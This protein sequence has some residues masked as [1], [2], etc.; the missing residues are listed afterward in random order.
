MTLSRSLDPI[1]EKV[2]GRQRAIIITVGVVAAVFIFGIS[3]W[4]TAPEWV[5]AFSNL[6]MESVG[7]MTEKLQQ[8]GVPYKLDK[9]GTQI[10]VNAKDLARARVMLAKD[11][12][13]TAGRPG[14]ELFDQPSWGMTDFTQRINYRRALEGELERTISKMRGV[15]SAQV[16][17]ALH[18][19]SNFR[20]QDKPANASIVLKTSGPPPTPD[21]VLGIAHLVAGSVDG[22]TSDRVTIIDDSGRLLSQPGENGSIATLTNSQ[23]SM[24]RDVE[25]YLQS[26]AEAIVNEIAGR[27]NGRVQVSATLNFDKIDRQSQ[28]VDPERQATSTEQRHDIVE[29]GEEGS[30]SSNVAISYENS[31]TTE[32]FSG[33][34]GNISRLSVAVLVNDRIATTS[35]DAATASEAGEVVYV[36]RTAE[37]VAHIESLVRSAV[38]ANEARGDVV[39]VISTRFGN[40]PHIRDTELADTPTLVDYAQRFQPAIIAI[41]GFITALIALILVFRSLK[42]TG[43]PAPAQLEP[44]GVPP[45]HQLVSETAEDDAE[46]KTA[47]P[48]NDDQFNLLDRTDLQNTVLATIENKP[49]VAARAIRAWMGE[50]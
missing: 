16:H 39:T 42:K 15:E 31:R 2:G 46:Q 30:T 47:L 6:P 11:G 33:A 35:P 14:L 43:L 41:L 7:A 34:I 36:S 49:N 29:T 3:R 21:V 19:Q 48:S 23:L 45:D 1:I 9:G 5:P 37:E 24:Q 44:A 38:G 22:L 40:A 27:G 17:L 25:Q 18:E 28:I 10:S 8:G 13:P 26:K 50:S 4:A 20:R 12:L 32:S